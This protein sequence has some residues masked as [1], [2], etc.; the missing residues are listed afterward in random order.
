[1]PVVEPRNTNAEVLLSRC[2]L[3]VSTG[4]SGELLFSGLVSLLLVDGS[5][6]FEA[7]GP[8]RFPAPNV[9]LESRKSTTVSGIGHGWYIRLA[10]WASLSWIFFRSLA[11]WTPN[12][13]SN[14][15]STCGR[16]RP[17][18]P[19]AIQLVDLCWQIGILYNL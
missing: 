13:T 15:A 7:P 6:P 5:D 3:G 14:L 9:N 1:M 2:D 16:P 19:S 4:T 8:S 12:Q 18:R 17:R 10:L 11:S